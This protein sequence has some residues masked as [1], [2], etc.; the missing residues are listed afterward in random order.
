VEA[1]GDQV[2]GLID[3]PQT[4]EHHGFD[5][6]TDSEVAHCRVLLGRLI[7]DLAHTEFVEHASDKAKVVDDVA[8]VR[9]LI[10]HNH[11]L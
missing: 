8:T 3:T 10:R 1:S 2:E 11:L 9:G 6:F 7:E 5:G 4:I